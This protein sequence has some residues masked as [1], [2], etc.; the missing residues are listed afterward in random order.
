[1]EVGT[2]DDYEQSHLSRAQM[3]LQMITT[4]LQSDAYLFLP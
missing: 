1:M 3:L 4:A 2:S